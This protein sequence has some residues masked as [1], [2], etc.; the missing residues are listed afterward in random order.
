MPQETMERACS[1][2]GIDG[3][4]TEESEVRALARLFAEG[5]CSPVPDFLNGLLPE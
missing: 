1:D 3:G 5:P 4:G 2:V